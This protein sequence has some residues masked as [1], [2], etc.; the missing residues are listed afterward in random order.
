MLCLPALSDTGAGIKP[1][2]QIQSRL[3]S[4]VNSTSEE[5]H[6]QDISILVLI[7]SQQHEWQHA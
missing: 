1:L 3:S 2:V 5:Y 4:A 6:H 7:R